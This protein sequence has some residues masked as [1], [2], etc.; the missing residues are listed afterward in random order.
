LNLRIP[1]V[2]T[3]DDPDDV[4]VA[5]KRNFIVPA[6]LQD[7]ERAN[8]FEEQKKEFKKNAERFGT[9]MFQQ[10]SDAKAPIVPVAQLGESTRL[11]P[12]E[13]RDGY[14][15]ALVQSRAHHRQET[16]KNSQPVTIGRGLLLN[17]LLRIIIKIYRRHQYFLIFFGINI[18]LSKHFRRDRLKD[19]PCERAPT[20]PETDYDDPDYDSEAEA[21]KKR[22][23]AEEA[24]KLKM[25]AKSSNH[26]KAAFGTGK[27][28]LNKMQEKGWTVA[29]G[30]QLIK[31][32]PKPKP[33]T[34][35]DG[36]ILIRTQ[37]GIVALGGK[38][39]IDTETMEPVAKSPKLEP[40]VISSLQKEAS[41]A[42]SAA[43]QDPGMDPS[44]S[45]IY[46]ANEGGLIQVIPSGPKF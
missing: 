40:K 9:A 33:R 37:D 24:R 20:P 3:I 45:G 19:F 46:D 31:P 39:P 4:V 41:S 30:G 1:K 36:A 6:E 13:I 26:T 38:E 35:G 14:A 10:R 32:K 7:K 18:K 28:I 8:K 16:P 12:A 5:Y 42:P 29:P 22:K 27:Q 25:R 34:K 11:N 23:R 17:K 15:A 21:E 43:P 2:R 44:S